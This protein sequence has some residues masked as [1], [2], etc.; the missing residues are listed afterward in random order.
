MKAKTKEAIGAVI[1]D[2]CSNGIGDQTA[3]AKICAIVEQ[4]RQGELVIANGRVARKI[5]KDKWAL[6]VGRL[7]RLIFIPDEVTK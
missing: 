4:E 3:L 2:L 6:M 7:G 5:H 1:E